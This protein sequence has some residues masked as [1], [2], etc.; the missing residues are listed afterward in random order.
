MQGPQGTARLQEGQVGV[1]FLGRGITLGRHAGARPGDDR[2][3]FE[4]VDGRI[5]RVVAQRQGGEFQPVPPRGHFIQNLAQRID[6]GLRRARSLWRNEPLGPH[7]TPG[8]IQPGHEPDVRQLGHATD[9][10]DVAGFDV[11]M[12]QARAMQGRQAAAEGQEV[13]EAVHHRQPAVF[14]RRRPQGRGDVAARISR[15]LR[16]LRRIRGTDRGRPRGRNVIRSLRRVREF[17]HIVETPFAVVAPDL[18]D[19]HQAFMRARHRLEL[20]HSRE[21]ALVG[22][23]AGETGTPHHLDRPER[24]DGGAG[25]PDI[26][27]GSGSDPQEKFVVRDVRGHPAGRSGKTGFQGRFRK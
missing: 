22:S 18:Q 6:I 13:A 12:D 7:E 24:P 8:V 17:H 20:Q 14:L 16:R 21:L 25:E 10:N 11:A 2:V 3:E 9:E 4:Q 1:E 5:P 26:T 19:V 15:G 27:I 23:G